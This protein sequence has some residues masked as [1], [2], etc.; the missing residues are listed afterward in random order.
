MAYGVDSTFFV[1]VVAKFGVG[2]GLDERKQILKKAMIKRGVFVVRTVEVKFHPVAGGEKHRFA[3]VLPFTKEGE[4]TLILKLR[5]P[6][7][8]LDGGGLVRQTKYEITR[9]L[10]SIAI[11]RGRARG[12]R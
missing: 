5:E 3:N 12:A 8:N 10:G 6:F 1:E 4:E 11:G 9:P 2:I 7:T